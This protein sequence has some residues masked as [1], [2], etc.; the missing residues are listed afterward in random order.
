MPSL[1]AGSSSTWLSR[2]VP[3]AWP[4]SFGLVMIVP[5]VKNRRP[6]RKSG[7]RRIGSASRPTFIEPGVTRTM[8]LNIHWLTAS[9]RPPTEV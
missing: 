8:L 4:P 6:C 1:P 9:I 5:S 7:A 3:R 2:P